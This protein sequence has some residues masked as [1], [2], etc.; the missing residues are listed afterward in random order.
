M[1]NKRMRQVALISLAVAA[2]LLVGYHYWP[3]IRAMLPG[4][5]TA[6]TSS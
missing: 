6:S 4:A 5:S 3:R 2:G 1:N